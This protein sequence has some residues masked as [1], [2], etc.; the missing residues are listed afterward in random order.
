MMFPQLAQ[1]VLLAVARAIARWDPDGTLRHDLLKR[2]RRRLARF[3]R[4]M[5]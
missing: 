4:F 3:L 2:V 1:T 5:G